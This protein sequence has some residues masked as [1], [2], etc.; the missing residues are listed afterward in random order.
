M[1]D[2][3]LYYDLCATPVALLDKDGT[4]MR[5]NSAFELHF[6]DVIHQS[7]GSIEITSAN[8]Q[9]KIEL[10]DITGSIASEQKPLSVRMGA[11]PDKIF[12]L[13]S[14][15]IPESGDLLIQCWDITQQYILEGKIA[16]KKTVLSKVI[17]S[18][19][20]GICA[21]DEQGIIRIWN[22][23]CE[24]IT[25]YSEEEIADNPQ[26]FQKLFATK[27]E[28]LEAFA[29][30]NI[31]GNNV[32]RNWDMEIKRKDGQIRILRM[33]VRYREKPI[34]SGLHQWV[35]ASD[36]TDLVQTREQL[37]LSEE[38]Y[39]IISKA[40]NDAVWDWDLIQ[41]ELWWNDGITELFDYDSREVENT[42]DWW[43]ERLH[44]DYRNQVFTRL[45]EH[46]KHG[47]DFWSDEYLFRKK[48][49]DY[50]YVYDRG[51]VL[52]DDHGKPYRMIGGMKDLSEQKE[53]EKL[54]LEKDEQLKE[55]MEYNSSKVVTPALRV[56]QLAL[57]L[58]LMTH[59]NARVKDHVDRLL[60]AARD[61]EKAVRSMN[62]RYK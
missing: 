6:G 58:A 11:L 26:G 21:Y 27:A 31:R 49:G 18:F 7:I 57:T 47:I 15:Q 41:N 29:K 13:S 55:I 5:I 33:T 4:I 25:G 20:E 22:N 16:E 28:M 43:V 52:K 10:K 54:S 45:E 37:K 46:A 24:E 30:W 53:F 61:A 9:K 59:E 23:R 62:E 50:A 34:I 19:P 38:R 2:F 36:I 8:Y 17:D 42:I 32:I 51:Y 48:N 56:T 14:S 60:L 1:K 40:T 39:R 35:I 3:N 44:P 12:R